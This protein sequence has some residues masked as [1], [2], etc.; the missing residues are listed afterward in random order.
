MTQIRIQP[1]GVHHLA[2]STGNVK[3]QIAFFTDVLGAE[4]KALYWIHL[5]GL[6]D[7]ERCWHAFLKLNDYCYLA[8]VEG[9]SYKN[10]K[11]IEGVSHAPNAAA[12]SAP[13]TVGHLAMNCASEQHL[14]ALRDRIRSRGILCLGPLDHGFCK[15]I[16]F[17]GPEGLNLEISTSEH[18]IDERAWIDPEVVAL[19]GISAEELQSYIHPVYYENK[20]KP[21]P[22]P[23]Y[24]PKKPH[25]KWSK[26]RMESVLHSSDED[27]TAA[28]SITEPPVK[29]HAG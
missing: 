8:F 20:G 4:L 26:E 7:A 6:K 25:P 3:Q 16:Y 10:I 23:A 9:P 21:L 18:P 13:G 14:L 12:S 5:A 1:N 11:P 28:L 24:D 29:E 22:Q 17:G 27:V 2:F 19:A 15:S